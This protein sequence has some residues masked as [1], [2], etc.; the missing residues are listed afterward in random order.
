MKMNI[1]KTKI[2]K[3]LIEEDP[4][5][6][7]FP[8]DKNIDEY[9]SEVEKITN[10]LDRCHNLKELT[11]LVSNILQVTI[12]N[13]SSLEQKKRYSKIAT[14]IWNLIAENNSKS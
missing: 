1:L 8:E 11:D 14:K 4:M 5:D 3:I 6:I 12:E 10:N 9:D 7:Y 2:R 13:Y